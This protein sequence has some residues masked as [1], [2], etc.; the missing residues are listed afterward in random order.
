LVEHHL[1]KVR[2]AG[3]SLVVRSRYVQVR[4]PFEGLC[5]VWSAA[6]YELALRPRPV[7]LQRGQILI[8]S[9]DDESGPEV[10]SKNVF[11]RRA[12]GRARRCTLVKV[13]M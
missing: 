3:S 5:F 7:V 10:C 9:P 2:V 13:V 12:R 8:T 6:L 11:R 4:G 1:A